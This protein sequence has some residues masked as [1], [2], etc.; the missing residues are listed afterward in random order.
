MPVTYN[1]KIKEE[2]IVIWCLVRSH[3]YGGSKRIVSWWREQPTALQLLKVMPDHVHETWVAPILITGM[4]V[5]PKAP[6][7]NEEYVFFL[8][9][10]PQG[11]T[12]DW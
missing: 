5:I 10:H 3:T 6:N 9:Q 2:P 4:L 12:L 8:E 11:E 7:T 1:K